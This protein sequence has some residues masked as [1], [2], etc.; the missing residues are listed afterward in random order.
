MNE[1]IDTLCSCCR[2]HAEIEPHESYLPL[3]AD[4][5]SR[6]FGAPRDGSPDGLRREMALLRKFKKHSLLIT[7]FLLYDNR[8]LQ[9]LLSPGDELK[10]LV[11]EA[12]DIHY[13]VGHSILPGV[14]HQ[15]ALYFLHAGW[16]E[17]AITLLQDAADGLFCGYLLHGQPEGQCQHHLSEC[18]I[19]L[20][21]I[22]ELLG[23]T[24]RQVWT[25]NQAELHLRSQISFC[26]KRYGMVQTALR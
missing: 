25:L 13:F 8:Q 21:G 3:C 11:K 6:L 2:G 9:R 18:Y 15:L 16:H 14:F 10:K 7:A 22:Y 4:C 19:Q 23:D 17:D 20:A 12:E 24:S 1:R 5:K 26:M